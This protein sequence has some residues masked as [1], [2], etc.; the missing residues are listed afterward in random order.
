[1][2]FYLDQGDEKLEVQ[3]FILLLA[4]IQTFQTYKVYLQW[5]TN[6]I[7]EIQAIYNHGKVSEIGDNQS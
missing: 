2:I 6:E 4:G 1:M 7:Y 3:S 5:Y